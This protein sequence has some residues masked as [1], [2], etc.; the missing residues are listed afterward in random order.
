MLICH[1]A[2]DGDA[3][4]SL[5]GLARALHQMGLNPV[6]ACSDPIPARFNYI[7][8]AEAVARDVSTAFDL[9]ISLDCSDP[10]R[11]GHFSQMPAFGSTPLLNIDHH[12]TNSGFGDVNLVDPDAS[13][14]AEIVLWLLESMAVPLDAELATALL[15]GIVTD[16]RGFRTSNV[17]VR[18]MEAAMQ[19]MKA[20]ASLPYITYHSLD[21]RPTA[22]VHL[23]GAAISQLRME[24]RVIWTSIPLAMRQAVG[25]TGNG[26][27]GLVS[28][29]ISADDADAAVVFVECEEGCIEVGLRAAPGFDVARVALQ[30]GGGGHTLAAGCYLPGPLEKAE[31]R[32]LDALQTALARQRTRET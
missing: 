14:T 29:L 24:D 16:T 13:S 15:A 2:P 32:M 28:F 20:R 8:G 9:I 3:V 11:L 18:V 1:I 22:A 17:T 10:K 6:M 4:G 19:L 5:T 25:Y 12:L 26:D 30:F 31:A 7:P 21:R 27:A 23:W